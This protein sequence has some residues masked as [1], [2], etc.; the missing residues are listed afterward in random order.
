VTWEPKEGVY[1]CLL[2]GNNLQSF[3]LKNKNT[4]VPGHKYI[5][6]YVCEPKR[7]KYKGNGE[8]EVQ[9]TLFFYD[10]N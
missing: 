9:A 5:P 8:S 1:I 3:F 4:L 6:T 10:L 7:K 2:S